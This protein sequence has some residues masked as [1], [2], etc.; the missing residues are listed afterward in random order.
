MQNRQS[1][2][3]LRIKKKENFKNLGE[4]TEYLQSV[5]LEL[6]QEVGFWEKILYFIIVNVDV[7]HIFTFDIDGKCS[8]GIISKYEWKYSA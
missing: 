2:S 6:R 8:R 3:R 4:E 7:I 5:N 1:A